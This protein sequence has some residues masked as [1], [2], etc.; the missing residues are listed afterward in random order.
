MEISSQLQKFTGNAKT[1]SVNGDTVYGCLID[2]SE[3]Y[4]LMSDFL[5]D[6]TGTLKTVVV[7]NGEVIPQKSLDMAVSSDDHLALLLPMDGG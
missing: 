7:I 1:V 4:P 6:M 3:R 2:L 5:F